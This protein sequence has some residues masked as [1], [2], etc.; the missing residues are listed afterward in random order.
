MSR[1]KNVT[2]KAGKR[3]DGHREPHG[4]GSPVRGPSVQPMRGRRKV[5]GTAASE[6]LSRLGSFPDSNRM[7]SGTSAMNGLETA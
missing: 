5:T 7:A 4:D 1:A 6:S 2:M 3:F